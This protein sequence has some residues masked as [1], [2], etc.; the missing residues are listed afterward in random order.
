MKTLLRKNFIGASLVFTAVMAVYLLTLAPTITNEDGPEFVTA[1]HV[2]GIPHPP[3]FPLY[4]LIGKIF[5]FIPFG[6]LG[7]RI[8]LMSAVFGALTAVMLYLIIQK[9]I[10]RY[11]ISFLVSLLLPF[12]LIF[13]SQSVTAEV[14]TLNTFFVALLIYLLMIWQQDQ[15]DKYLYWFSLLYGLCLTNHTMSIVLAPAFT[16]FILLVNKKIIFNWRLIVKMFGLF[17]LGLSV[18]LYIPIRAWQQAVYNWGPIT[19]WQ[20]VVA[21]ITRAKYG[22]LNPFS[23]SY[24]KTGIVLSFLYDIYRQFFWPTII[25]AAGGVV[26]FWKKNM[27]LAAL[28]V[29]I[30]LLNSFGLIYL[31]KYGFALGIDHTYRVY[32]LPA[33]FVL[34]WWLA[35]IIDYLYQFLLNTIKNNAK[36]KA[37]V[38]ATLL[39]ILLSLPVSFVA[40]NF[41]QNDLSDYWLTYDYTKGLLSS[42]EP[43]SIY[44][45]AYD[46]SLQTDTEIFAL[47]YFKMVENFRPDVDIISEQNFF[48]KTVNVK[49]P[50][51]HYKLSFEDRRRTFF[52]MVDSVKDRPLYANYPLTSENNNEKKFSLPNGYAYR[53]YPSLA[54]AR[55]AN[56]QYYFGTMRNLLEVKDLI[57]Q[58]PADDGL[59]GH[60]FYNLAAIYLVEGDRVKSQDYL[61]KAIDFD[62]APFNH[63]YHRFIQYRKEWSGN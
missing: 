9:T 60:Y 16:L 28:T 20:D 22:D 5:S 26:Y 51:E 52:T 39:I 40:M 63:E 46:G 48:Y 18:Y 32:Y 37:V 62:T 42:L 33:Y 35:I 45:F 6:T 14:Y 56:Q 21:H 24:S 38:Q 43:N 1:I 7:W 8:N 29:G 30:F 50:D 3:G 49:I 31:R 25:L 58:N 11:V 23:S 54:E 15:K 36:L 19:T 47:I 41:G 4:L 34:V 61:V 2:L 59:I 57:H 55:R 12:S 53:A 27:P 13:W 44:Y 10:S 17:C